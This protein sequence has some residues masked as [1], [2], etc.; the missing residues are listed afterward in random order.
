MSADL[1]DKV[2]LSAIVEGIP[3]PSITWL[4]DG[5][6][7]IGQASVNVIDNERTHHGLVLENIKVIRSEAN[8]LIM[9]YRCRLQPLSFCFSRRVPPT[10]SKLETSLARI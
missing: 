6:T 9:C 4:K 7:L 3:L 8:R 2:E 5:Q 10:K 1:G